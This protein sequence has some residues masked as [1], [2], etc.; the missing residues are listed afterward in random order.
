[1]ALLYIQIR[2]S[3]PPQ[4]GWRFIGIAAILF[5]LWNIDTFTV[6]VIR[7]SIT[8]DMFTGAART[9]D[10]YVDISS[11]RGKLFYAG[12]ILDHVFLVGAVWAFLL[13]II[14]FSK[15]TEPVE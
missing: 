14:S 1:M 10:Q 12:K 7:E 11:I 8:R 5:I 4:K 15:E 9:W 6:H 2:K 3:K 13:G